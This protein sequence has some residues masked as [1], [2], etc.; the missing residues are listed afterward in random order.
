MKEK[1]GVIPYFAAGF[2]AI[3][4]IG[5]FIIIFQAVPMAMGP[6]GMVMIP[7]TM[8]MIRVAAGK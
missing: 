1:K 6:G 2:S 3:F 4:S 7:R 8:T 5:I